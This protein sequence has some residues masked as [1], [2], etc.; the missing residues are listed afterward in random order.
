MRMVMRGAGADLGGALAAL[1]FLGFEALVG[2]DVLGTSWRPL[3]R[4]SGGC[5]FSVSYTH[6]RAHET[7]S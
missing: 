4:A 6:L 2:L 1:S 5:C 7:L 3:V